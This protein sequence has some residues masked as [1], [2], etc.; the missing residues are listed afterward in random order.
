[1]AGWSCMNYTEV[2][3]CYCTA[4]VSTH[5]N[6][7]LLGLLR[8]CSNTQNWNHKSHTHVK[9]H[10]TH[11]RLTCTDRVCNAG[12]VTPPAPAAPRVSETWTCLCPSQQAH[13]VFNA[14]V[15][16]QSRDSWQKTMCTN[17]MYWY[18]QKK[19]ITPLSTNDD[20]KNCVKFTQPTDQLTCR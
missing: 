11:T 15:K 19:R 9:F 8:P 16:N 18:E 4:A 10:I 12:E 13:C 1:M 17:C 7:T 6:I 5:K 14:M 20:E 2:C 3:W